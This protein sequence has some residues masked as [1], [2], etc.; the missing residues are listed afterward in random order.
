MMLKI[1]L[2]VEAAE[3]GKDTPMG[4]EMVKEVRG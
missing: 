2:W 4:R 3:G 1:R